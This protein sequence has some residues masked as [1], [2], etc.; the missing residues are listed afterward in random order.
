MQIR[1]AVQF[2]CSLTH[3]ASPSWRCCS[4]EQNPVPCGGEQLF[5]NCTSCVPCTD[6]F[7]GAQEASWEHLLYS[8]GFHCVQNWSRRNA[9]ALQWVGELR[10]LRVTASGAMWGEKSAKLKISTMILWC[11][12]V[13]DRSDCSYTGQHPGV[14]VCKCVMLSFLKRGFALCKK[15]QNNHVLLIEAHN[16]PAGANALDAS[17]VLVFLK[18]VVI[19]SG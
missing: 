9:L 6:I 8:Q 11:C 4:L 19:I 12:S 10:L 16:Y 18:W 7:A 1:W 2:W 13:A 14:N 5:C 15:K 17:R 3:Y